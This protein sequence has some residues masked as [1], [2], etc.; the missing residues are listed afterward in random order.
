MAEVCWFC[1]NEF[2]RLEGRS[3]T[4][5]KLGL[6]RGVNVTKINTGSHI[7]INKTGE[8]AGIDIPRC[9]ACA[10]EVRSWDLKTAWKPAVVGLVI[11]LIFMLIVEGSPSGLDFYIFI[12]GGA[13][14][15]LIFG[16]PIRVAMKKGF[17]DQ[18][19]LSFPA[20]KALLASGWIISGRRTE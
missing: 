10:K 14:V 13:I 8:G 15:G 20:L 11:G 7:Y 18:A 9:P 16:I 2:D 17:E 6:Q 1:R 3:N 5:L 12:A 19:A 4:D